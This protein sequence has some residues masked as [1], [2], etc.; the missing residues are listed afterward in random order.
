MR[1][2]LALL[3]DHA[4]AHPTD[5]K[6]YITGGGLRSLSFSAFP[7]T[8]AHLA[9]ALGIELAPDELDLEHKLAIQAT[10]PAA[11]PIFRP[12]QVTFALP[13]AGKAAVD[14]HINFVSNMD[15]VFFPSEGEYTFQA[16]IDDTPLAEV[17][18]RVDGRGSEPVDAE[19]ANLREAQSMIA[20]GY[21]AFT[22]GDSPKAEELFRSAVKR[23]PTS[24]AA[25]N[26][27]GFVLL[28]KGEAQLALEAFGEAARLGYPQN[29]ITDANVG[30]ALFLLRSYDASLKVFADCL[31]TRVFRTTATL[32]GIDGEGLFPVEIQ[33]AAGY[34]ALMA[35]NAGW[36]ADRA[37]DK[38]SKSGYVDLARAGESL[39]VGDATMSFGRAL[40]ALDAA[41]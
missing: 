3:A 19:A 14:D 29:E 21:E 41:R 25:H 18:L 22:A 24:S 1:I 17:L 23:V 9:L 8:Y 30:C 36:S 16:S 13:S 32:F 33:S 40:L 35:L 26:N 31:R 20:A 5:G 34:A 15:N 38:A 7:A 28:F 39:L 37:G 10:G 6:L 4:L 27:L 12:V 2:P 11:A